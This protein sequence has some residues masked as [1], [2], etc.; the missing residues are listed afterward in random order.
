MSCV[1]NNLFANTNN[2]YIAQG[3]AHANYALLKQKNNNKKIKK[4]IIYHITQY[5]TYQV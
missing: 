1:I 3:E 4:T 5:K 2:K